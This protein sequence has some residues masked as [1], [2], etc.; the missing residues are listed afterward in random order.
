MGLSICQ[1]SMV[2]SKKK[3]EIGKK[4]YIKSHNFALCQNSFGGIHESETLF[5]FSRK[6]FLGKS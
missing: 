4:G 5:N 3:V 6:S 1:N 2:R